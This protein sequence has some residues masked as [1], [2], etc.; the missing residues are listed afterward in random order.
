VHVLSNA[1]LGPSAKL[2][3]TSARDN[4]VLAHHLALELHHRGHLCAIFP[5]LVSAVKY[6]PTLGVDT[7]GDFFKDGSMPACQ[8]GIVVEAVEGKLVE[9]LRRLGKGVPLLTANN[10]TVKAALAASL[11]IKVSRCLECALIPTMSLLPLSV[12]PLGQCHY[13][14]ALRLVCLLNVRSYELLCV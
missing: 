6:N 11:A 14:I 4:V 5:I 7:Y 3:T 10:F 13:N 1:A 12:Y 2:T 8:G 9:H